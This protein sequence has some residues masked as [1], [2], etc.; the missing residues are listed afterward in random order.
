[1]SS[2]DCFSMAFFQVWW[3]VI[4]TNV[5]GVFHDFHATSKFEKNLNATFIALIPKKNGAM[6]LKDFRPISLMSGVYKIITKVLANK[7]RRVVEKIISKPQNAFVKG[8]Q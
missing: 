5:M 1:V 4:K 3:E 2:P 7:L 8:R 6:D